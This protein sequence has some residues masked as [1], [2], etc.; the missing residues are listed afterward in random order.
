MDIVP[1]LGKAS[2]AA[3]GS[4]RRRVVVNDHGGRPFPIDLSRALAR[5]GHRVTHVCGAS[6]GLD[7]GAPIGD[8]GDLRVAVVGT[9]PTE[10]G[11]TWAGRLG[12]DLRY[13][14]RSAWVC[15]RARAQVVIAAPM[16]TLS[17][18][19]MG[20]ILWPFGTRRVLWFQD[21]RADRPESV[22]GNG[23]RLVDG[24]VR[25]VEDWSLRRADAVVAASGPLAAYARAVGVAEPRVTVLENWAPVE[26]I[27]VRPRRND[28][29][30]RMGLA[31]GL[32]FVYTGPLGFEHRPEL[33]VALGEELAAVDPGAQ[34]VVAASGPGASRLAEILARRP[35]L[36]NLVLMPT[37]RF[38]EL[39]DVL[40]AADV[41]V[42]LLDPEAAGYA[43]PANVPGYL[44]AG[45]PVLGL[46]PYG[47]PAERTITRFARAGLVSEQAATFLADARRLADDRE[48]RLTLGKRG[49]DWAE[50][51][52][53]VGGLAD[54]FERILT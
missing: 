42:T 11:S 1:E 21:R 45:R 32:N 35:Q 10:S 7:L 26:E 27:P 18:L 37:P 17:L 5:R 36:D 9:G 6:G 12:A 30:E 4:G 23:R 13:G 20:A 24:A 8:D 53:P 28:W 2:P 16:P 22:G 3:N 33:L 39:P 51:H 46:L 25:C 38:R 34:V 40:G 19:L 54:H 44:C 47:N 29:S 43:V 41:L 52:F 50:A 31:A 48:L 14:V 15:R 49:R